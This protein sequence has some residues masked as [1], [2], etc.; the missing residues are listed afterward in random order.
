M[1]SPK[2]I[3]FTVGNDIKLAVDAFGP[4]HGRPVLLAHGGGQTRHAW[5]ACGNVLGA[6]GYHAL[7]LDLRGHGESD[8]APDGDYAIERFAEDIL[9]IAGKLKEAPVMVGA[10]LG[11]IAGLIAQ[12]ELAKD[13]RRGFAGLVLVD[14]TPRMS[15][16]GVQKILG[17]MS[18]NLA[19]GFASLQEA[20]DAIGQYLPHRPRPKSLSGLAKNLRL[21]DD[22]RYYWHWDP[23]F[24]TGTQR[25]QGS[26]EPE[27]LE[28]AAR[29]VGV[30]TLLIRGDKSELVDAEAVRR[31][32]E[33][34]P[35]S[36]FVDV[37][38][39]GH[40][41]AGDSNNVFNEAVVDFLTRMFSP[42]RAAAPT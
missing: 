38:D 39:A 1:S 35:H 12:G 30:P 31:F 40:M 42:A 16:E 27:R 18:S 19:T 13:E 20:A 11:G 15:V 6:R 34:V 25:P 33:L 9:S 3:S 7:C 4:E 26:R 32:A 24:I 22:G 2:R 36:E 29:N 23:R 5:Q 8:W 21:K 17:F 41:V 10:S 28:H 37:T 14:I